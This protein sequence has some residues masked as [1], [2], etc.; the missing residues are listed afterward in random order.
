MAR[1]GAGSFPC[2]QRERLKSAAGLATG[3]VKVTFREHRMVAEVAEKQ[4]NM[5]AVGHQN[6]HLCS[7]VHSNTVTVQG[8]PISLCT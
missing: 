2:I 3:C 5:M 7:T 8:I 4:R 1:S 6:K